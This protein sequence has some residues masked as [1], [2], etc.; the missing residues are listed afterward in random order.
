MG[1]AKQRTKAFKSHMQRW[2][3]WAA[4]EERSLIAAKVPQALRPA[5]KREFRDWK[6][7]LVNMI[8]TESGIEEDGQGGYKYILPQQ[9]V[10]TVVNVIIREQ[11]RCKEHLRRLEQNKKDGAEKEREEE[12]EAA[13]KLQEM[14]EELV[15]TGR[16]GG[17]GDA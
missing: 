3:R 9:L 16:L 5:V 1:D 7:T 2:L 8:M 11:D 17:G 6:E 15:A 14:R 10:Q 13:A 12:K 4:A